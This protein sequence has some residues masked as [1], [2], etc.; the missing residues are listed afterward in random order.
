MRGNYSILLDHLPTEV[1]RGLKMVAAHHG[2]GVRDFCIALIIDAINLELSKIDNN[3]WR[4]L[5]CSAKTGEVKLFSG[6]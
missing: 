5:E 6:K 2:V 4:K 3:W 1:K